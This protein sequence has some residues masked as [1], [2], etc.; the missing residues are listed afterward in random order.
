MDP[1]LGSALISGGASIV[2]GLLG[3]KKSSSKDLRKSYQLQTQYIPQQIKAKVAGARAAGLHPLAAIGM[4]PSG[5]PAPIIPGQNE[6]G[7][8][9]G[10]GIE[11]AA[12]V[13]NQGKQGEAM[14]QLG[15]LKLEEQKLRNEYLAQQIRHNEVKKIS[16]EAIPY[17]EQY[18]RLRLT[19]DP[20]LMATPSKMQEA[21]DPNRHIEGKTFISSDG[22]VIAIPP[23]TPAEEYERHFGDFGPFMPDNI[24]RFSKSFRDQLWQMNKRYWDNRIKE[25]SKHFKNRIKEGLPYEQRPLQSDWYRRF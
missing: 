19:R 7:S 3:R 21:L 15:A 2:G 20:K 17:P 14:K 25:Y 11:T 18:R 9:I 6:T 22:D 16:Q 12:N 10:Q 5:Q 8:I 24:K 4:S 13:Y 1:V 23:G